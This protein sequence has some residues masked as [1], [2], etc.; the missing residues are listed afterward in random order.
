MK[1]VQCS[2]RY[3]SA[4]PPGRRQ[5]RRDA[6]L[7]ASKADVARA[8][9]LGR[10]YDAEQL[11]LEELRDR[12]P[13]PLS[14]APGRTWEGTRLRARSDAP[15]RP[16][17]SKLRRWTFR[18]VARMGTPRRLP[19][20]LGRQRIVPRGLCDRRIFWHAC[21]PRGQSRAKSAGV[22]RWC[23]LRALR[24]LLSAI[25]KGFVEGPL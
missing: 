25:D 15:S 10:W 1:W 19:R 22:E 7:P 9:A 16:R 2:C 11:V 18:A 21:M 6:R 3:P 4:L 8:P 24:P 12:A 20:M 23:A 5:L 13:T 17:R 14:A